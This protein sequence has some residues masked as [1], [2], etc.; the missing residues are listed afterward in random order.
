[1]HLRRARPGRTDVRPR[2]VRDRREVPRLRDGREQ[3]VCE[4]RTPP[5]A[6]RGE[7]RPPR[8]RGLRI[9][10]G[11]PVE[12]RH[13]GSDRPVLSGDAGAP[14]LA[15]AG[16]GTARIVDPRGTPARS[17]PAPDSQADLARPRSR[18]LVGDLAWSGAAK[19]ED[20]HLR[21]QLASLS[22]TTGP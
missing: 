21:V 20:F 1:M 7:V 6:R 5:G 14:G 15:R 3:G 4:P 17:T 10:E 16:S 22:G 13:A 19:P 12:G 11:R 18:N 9:R 8:S 2:T